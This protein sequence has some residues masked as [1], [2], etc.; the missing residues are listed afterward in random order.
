MNALA[1]QG[2]SC[3]QSW[4][5]R[6]MEVSGQLHVPAALPPEK[7]PL[8]PLD[9]RLGKPHSRSGSGGEDKNSQPLLWLE[10]PIIHPVLQRYTTELS[11]IL[12]FYLHILF[13]FSDSRTGI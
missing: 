9:R 6:Y 1:E 7:E 10:P 12:V 5:R 8:V 13:V 2:Y 11:R 4:P 3:T